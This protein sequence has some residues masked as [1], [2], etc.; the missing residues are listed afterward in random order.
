MT[1]GDV[2]NRQDFTGHAKQSCAHSGKHT[3]LSCVY[4]QS[5]FDLAKG[6]ED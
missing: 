4:T 5:G 6:P 2:S 1:I 3:V